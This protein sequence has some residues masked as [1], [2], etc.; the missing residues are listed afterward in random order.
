[1]PTLTGGNDT[2]NAP[3]GLIDVDGGAG[4]DTLVIDYSTLTLP[5]RYDWDGWNTLFDDALNQVR[6]TGFERISVT[7]GSND[8]DLRGFDDAAGSDVLRGGA[9]NDDLAPG[10]GADS[11]DGG[12][13]IDRVLID[14]RAVP[15]AGHSITLL[16]SGVTTVATT[17]LKIENVERLWFYGSNAGGNDL[18]DTR[19]FAGNDYAFGNLGND[20]IALGT[21][22]DQAEGGTGEDVLVIDYASLAMD[23]TTWDAPGNWRRF[24]DQANG[25]HYTEYNGFERFA[26]TGGSGNDLIVGDVLADTLSGGLG[27]DTLQ[28]GT[29]VTT[30]ILN[31]GDGRDLWMVDL[32][33]MAAPV[34]IDISGAAQTASTGT[35][36]SGIEQLAGWMGSGSDLVKLNAGQFGDTLDL[37]SGDDTVQSGRGVDSFAGGS[38]TDRLVM[39]WSQVLESISWTD[40]GAGYARYGTA[41]GADR[42]DYTGFEAFDLTGGKKDDDLRGGAGADTLKGGAG[43]DSLS[44]F[45]GDAVIDGGT[46]TDLW[47]ADLSARTTG[48]AVSLA[49]S[50]TTAQ[51]GAAGLSVRNIERFALTT[52]SGNDSIDAGGFTG[53]D[54]VSLG[55]GNDVF[56]SGLGQDS[57]D[58]GTGADTL[59]VDYATVTA[60]LTFTDLTYGWARLGQA[61]AAANIQFVGFESYDIR[62]GTNAD[63]F[64]AGAGNDTLRGGDGDDSLY[65]AG[66]ADSIDGGAGRDLWQADYATYGSTSISIVLN[67]A[68]NAGVGGIGAA[69]AGIEDIIV[70]TASGDD[71]VDASAIL[72]GNTDLVLGAG[73]DTA[74]LGDGRGRVDMG[75]GTDTLKVDFSTSTTSVRTADLANGWTR[76]DDLAGMNRIDW[77]G[78]EHLA[79]SG[80]SADDKLFGG[81]GNDTLVGNA[82]NDILVGGLGD[83]Q[84]TGG[85]GADIFRVGPSW[86]N[87]GTDTITDAAAGDII[88]LDHAV[89]LIGP[90]TLGSGA[91]VGQ[92]R[93]QLEVTTG[94]TG[95]VTTLYIGL[96]TSVGAADAVVRLLGTYAPSDFSL[97]GRLISVLAGSSAGGSPGAD[98]LT[99]TQ[100]NDLLSGGDGTDMLLGRE[101]ADSLDGGTGADT[102]VGGV[103][104]D[105]LTGGGGA[106]VFRYTALSESQAGTLFRDVITD[107]R[108]GADVIDLSAVDANPVLSGDQAFAFIGTAGFSGAAGQLRDAGG[109]VAELDVN[110]DGLA[111]W[112]V[113]CTGILAFVAGDFVL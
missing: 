4:I 28:S 40:I 2:Y 84:M 14:Y 43:N 96:D 94:P 62:L 67:A 44:S 60:K 53:N 78:A 59:V 9:G 107:L 110:G 92:G 22:Q 20:T 71:L 35:T 49:G 75:G 12:T 103:E 76:I 100:G 1:M 54:S 105:Q 85:A 63:I 57:A 5:I 97:G 77:Y 70:T 79:L 90:V 39:D 11:V 68:G 108:N 106:D 26:I 36:I 17:N 93:V 37:G 102:L 72:G 74:I 34:A 8:D 25:T 52:G 18:I 19:A 7:G 66:G 87:Y 109:G 42:L 31:G 112:Q 55:A 6:Y 21:G 89:T 86:L 64:K 33:T 73:S 29:G 65:G 23:L 113:Q 50:Q 32:R 91:S 10:R 47:S 81:S 111:D 83:D 13:G 61:G 46:G 104:K 24:G 30:D 38:G 48:I 95:P 101:G 45:A 82:G 16:A 99:G 3:L 58:G 98:L 80:G 27:N 51:G 41:S 69:V 15:A 88:R 56:A